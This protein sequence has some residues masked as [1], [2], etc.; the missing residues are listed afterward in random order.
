M[1]IECFVFEHD[2][3]R[4]GG[5]FTRIIQVG[6]AITFV[7]SDVGSIPT[8]GALEVWQWTV[9]SRTVWLVNNSGGQAQFYNTSVQNRLVG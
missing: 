3:P 5:I 7:W 1:L 8:C 6:R 2:D 9:G 4:H